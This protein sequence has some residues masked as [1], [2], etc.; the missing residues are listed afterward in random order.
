[1]NAQTVILAAGYA[2]LAVAA[3]FFFRYARHTITGLQHV[4]IKLRERETELNEREEELEEVEN[5]LELAREALNEEKA[6]VTLAQKE[7]DER[8]ARWRLFAED[9]SKKQESLAN[10]WE[11]I[12]K[13]RDCTVEERETF[14]HFA[15]LINSRL[16]RL[17]WVGDDLRKVKEA[18]A[19]EDERFDRAIKSIEKLVADANKKRKKSERYRCE[20]PKIGTKSLTSLDDTQKIVEDKQKHGIA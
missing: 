18:H 2:L 12:K 9:V 4:E 13:Y 15:N 7:I 16:K 14:S 20:E 5:G 19:I 11:K 6:R 1:M 3:F 8:E 10:E 17:E